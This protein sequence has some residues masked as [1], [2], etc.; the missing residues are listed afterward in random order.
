M[1]KNKSS[2][3]HYENTGGKPGGVWCPWSQS[4][5]FPSLRS[6]QLSRADTPEYPDVARGDND[7]DDGDDDDGEDADDADD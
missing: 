6:P 3:S 7:D 4:P 5:L 2:K 1:V